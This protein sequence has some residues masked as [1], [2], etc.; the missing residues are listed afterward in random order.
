MSWVRLL[1]YCPPAHFRNG[2]TFSAGQRCLPGGP[3][4]T[5]SW[6]I[7]PA[8]MGGVLRRSMEALHPNSTIWTIEDS[9]TEV[10]EL[11]L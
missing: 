11:T 1:I 2:R 9:R 8:A 10:C 3:A 4:T 7:C 6:Q 5:S